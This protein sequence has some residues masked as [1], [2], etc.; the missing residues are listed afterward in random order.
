MDEAALCDRIALIQDGKILEIDTPKAIV[1]HFP[2]T[3]YNI[4]ATNMY[5]LIQSLN[6][7][8]YN[9]SVFPFGEFV[10]YSDQRLDF[11]LED[12]KAYL[13]EKGLKDISI[14]ITQP[15]IEDTFMEL[16]K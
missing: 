6:A 14:E 2:K 13:I 10:H 7:Y 11:K 12:L 4:K 3:I 16:A 8:T 9:Y 5:Q 15:T 1:K